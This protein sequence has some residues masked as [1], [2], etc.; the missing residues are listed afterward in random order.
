MLGIRLHDRN[1]VVFLHNMTA[2]VVLARVLSSAGKG[3]C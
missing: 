2:Q 1:L 3:T